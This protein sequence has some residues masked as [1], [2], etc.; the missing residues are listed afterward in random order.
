MSVADELEP[1]SMQDLPRLST[2]DEVLADLAAGRMAI[3]IEQADAGAEGVL[4]VAADAADA[5]AVN[6]MATHGRGLVQLALPGEA[7]D[8]LGLA[9]QEV[10]GGARRGVLAGSPATVSIEARVGVSTGISAPDRARTIAVAID[11][12]STADDLATPGHV[13]PLRTC[14]GGVLVQAGQAEAAVDLARLAGRRPAA[15]LCGIMTDDGSM[16]RLPDLVRYGEKHGLRIVSVTDL[17]AWRLRREAAVKLV[18]DARISS[19]WGGEWRLRVFRDLVEQEEHYAL[20][21]GEVGDGRPALARMH[22]LDPLEDVLGLDARRARQ[23]PD[24]MEAI[25]REGRGVLVMLRDHSPAAISER[26]S[27]APRGDGT[28]RRHGI[29]AAILRELGVAQVELLTNAPLPRF[30]GL[31]GFGLEIVGARKF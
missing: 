10:R 23:A 15:A 20:T 17:I 14:E 4:V 31:D 30:A 13:F 22:A 24:A 2:V 8:R 6:F 5:A 19:I 3:L 29:G 11:P 26:L 27:G 25:A 7:V 21:K 9:P 16:A 1:H 28:L 18:E 12:G